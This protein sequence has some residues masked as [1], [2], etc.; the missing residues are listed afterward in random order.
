MRNNTLSYHSPEAE[1]VFMELECLLAES[2][3]GSIED[4]PGVDVISF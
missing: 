3:G 4:M 2:P 1:E